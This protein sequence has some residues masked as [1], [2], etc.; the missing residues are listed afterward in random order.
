M[1]KNYI[2]KYIYIFWI[3]KKIKKKNALAQILKPN[4]ADINHNYENFFCPSEKIGKKNKRNVIAFINVI[5]VFNQ[6]C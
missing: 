6:K 3:K 2:F 1:N 5:L 4:D